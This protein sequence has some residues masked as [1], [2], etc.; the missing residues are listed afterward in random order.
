MGVY[1]KEKWLFLVIF[2]L[3]RMFVD[4]KWILGMFRDICS[5]IMMFV[6]LK[7]YFENFDKKIIVWY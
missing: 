2:L 6:V 1:L 7:Y 4:F 3:F 5:L